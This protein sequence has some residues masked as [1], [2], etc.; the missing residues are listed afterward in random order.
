MIAVVL[1]RVARGEAGCGN[2][3]VDD[4]ECAVG[5]G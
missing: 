3:I 5:E 2:G 1:C 4:D